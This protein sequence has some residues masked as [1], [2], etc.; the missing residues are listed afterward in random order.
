MDN[1]LNTQDNQGGTRHLESTKDNQWE[2]ETG[3]QGTNTHRQV[4]NPDISPPPGRCILAPWKQHG[5]GGWELRR[6]LRSRMN[7]WR[8]PANRVQEGDK[9]TR[10]IPQSISSPSKSSS[11]RCIISSTSAT[12]QGHCRRLSHLV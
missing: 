7:T 12:V 9:V 1:T 6:R 3:S 5:E 8:G 4:H 10:S 2:T 11:P